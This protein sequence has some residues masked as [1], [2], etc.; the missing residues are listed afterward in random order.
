LHPADV[1]K[2]MV[3]LEALVD[4]GNTVIVAEHEM[5]V[6]AEADWIIDLGPGPGDQG[7]RVV[8]AATPHEVAAHPSSRTATYLAPLLAAPPLQTH[9]S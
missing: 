2:L 1:D 8:V 7:G 6:A 3:Q 4:A 9:R 5:R